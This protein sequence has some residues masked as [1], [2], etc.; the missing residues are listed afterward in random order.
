MMRKTAGWKQLFA[1]MNWR[2]MDW[3]M[4]SRRRRRSSVYQRLLWSNTY[5]TR[6]ENNSPNELLDTVEF[7]VPNNIPRLLHE[8]HWHDGSFASTTDS[9]DCGDHCT[10]K[11]FSQKFRPFRRH[12][13]MQLWIKKCLAT[14]DYGKIRIGPDLSWFQHSWKNRIHG[15]IPLLPEI[16]LAWRRYDLSWCK[17]LTVS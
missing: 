10:L 6:V 5:R 12:P 16:Q 11:Y 8:L 4:W 13:S 3:L 1:R 17:L 15:K 14:H 7:K 9:I 2:S